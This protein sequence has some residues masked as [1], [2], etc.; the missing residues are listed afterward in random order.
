MNSEIAIA[1]KE[2]TVRSIESYNFKRNLPIRVEKKEIYKIIILIILCFITIVI[3]TGA[4]K[5]AD[6][7]KRF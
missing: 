3:P 5:E 1:Q 4:K 2:D 6:K 7:F